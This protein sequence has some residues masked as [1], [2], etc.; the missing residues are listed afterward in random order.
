MFNRS[1]N[2][3]R[4]CTGAL[5]TAGLVVFVFTADVMVVNGRSVCVDAQTVEVVVPD[6]PVLENVMECQTETIHKE[7]YL[8]DPPVTI[9]DNP[10]PLDSTLGRVEGPSG[11]ETYYNLNM[12]N[13]VKRLHDL[14]YEGEY[15]V[16]EDGCKM[17]GDYIM[18]AADFSIRPLGTILESSLGYCIV[19]DTGEFIYSNPT[20]IDIAVTW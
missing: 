8:A 7:V 4:R 17:F 18:C 11:Q 13:C 15:W 6:A 12:K 19:A 20:Q 5:L 9:V 3:R 1:M 2:L 14:G 16:R 10:V